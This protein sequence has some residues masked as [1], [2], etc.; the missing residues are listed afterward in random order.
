MDNSKNATA[1]IVGRPNVGKSTLL[2][3]LIGE[4]IAIVSDKPQTTRTRIMGI[5]TSNEDQIIFI[6]T[7]GFHKA[8]NKLSKY[9]LDQIGGS[10]SDVDVIVF[11]T[12]FEKEITKSEEELLKNIKSS[13]IPVILAVNKI[14]ML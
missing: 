8:K 5:L 4:K 6:D 14:D 7:P 12:D 13:K 11:V 10:V 9:M 3:A 2:N 1:A